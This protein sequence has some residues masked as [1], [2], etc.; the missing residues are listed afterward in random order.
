MSN[1]EF[2]ELLVDAGIMANPFDDG[3]FRFVTH[4]EVTSEMVQKA[5]KEIRERIIK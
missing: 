2:S 5:I 3:V 4:R 1:E